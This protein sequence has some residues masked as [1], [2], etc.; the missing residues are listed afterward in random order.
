MASSEAMAA[1]RT[2][3][4]ATRR[5]FAGDQLMLSESRKEIRRRFEE[6]RQVASEGEVRQLVDQAKEASHFI[7]H[8]I[9]QAKRTPS[10]SFG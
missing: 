1:Y 2:L 4:R 7:Q 9:V 8:M 10:G 6:N 5:T 3:L